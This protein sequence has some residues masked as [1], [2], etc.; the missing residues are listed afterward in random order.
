[1]V[2]KVKF[3]DGDFYVDPEIVFA[4]QDFCHPAAGALRCAWPVGDFY[5]D[6]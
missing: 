2:W 6:Y 4:A 1:M 5:V 3:A